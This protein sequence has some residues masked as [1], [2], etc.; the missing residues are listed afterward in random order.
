MFYFSA[1]DSHVFQ[2]RVISRSLRSRWGACSEKYAAR[3]LSPAK[4]V[5]IFSLEP[6]PVGLC[7]VRRWLALLCW[8]L[9]LLLESLLTEPS[10]TSLRRKRTF[11]SQQRRKK[12]NVR[13][14]ENNIWKATQ[15]DTYHSQALLRIFCL[16]SNERTLPCSTIEQKTKSRFVW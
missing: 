4:S 8:R 6:C 10:A 7:F 11:V 3:L 12:E 14:T 13:S 1:S 16:H 5:D 2:N 9:C 15:W